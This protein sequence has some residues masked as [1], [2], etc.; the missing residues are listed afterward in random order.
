M[1]LLKKINFKETIKELIILLIIISF[2]LTPIPYYTTTGGGSLNT[3]NKISLEGAKEKKGSFRLA[4]VKQLRGTPLTY[5]LG[6][7][8]PSWKVD[9]ILDYAYED[10][11]NVEDLDNRSQLDLHESLQSAT[12]NAYEAAGMSFI[13]KK[14]A[15]K[16]YYASPKNRQ[17]LKV[18][19]ELITYDGNKMTD[20]DSFKAYIATKS[21]GDKIDLEFKRK[22]KTISRS[23][24]IFKEKDKEILGIMLIKIYD[25]ETAPQIKFKFDRGD[26]GPSGGFT[27]ALAIYDKLAVNDISRGR[28][29]VGTGTIDDKGRIGEIGGIIYKLDG[30][31]KAKADL[32]IVPIGENYKDAKA[33]AKRRKAKIK[34]VAVKDLK[35]AISLLEK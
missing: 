21:L 15:F 30:A 6:K 25:Y 35:E 22:N 33:E 14:T 23:L 2:S 4:Y 8:I 3:S 7:V 20:I 26:Q 12:K 28:K 17:D 9:S 10:S 5:L 16:L 18:G 34:I 19:D 11:E 31:I 29:I 24:K 1:K 13:I 32:F 27:L